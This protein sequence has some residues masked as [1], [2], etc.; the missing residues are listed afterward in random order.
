M[1]TISKENWDKLNKEI[2]VT[3]IGE[4]VQ[5]GS[6]RITIIDGKKEMEL[7]VSAYEHFKK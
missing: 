2:P 4:V 5:K 3:A 7:P 1:G 6:G